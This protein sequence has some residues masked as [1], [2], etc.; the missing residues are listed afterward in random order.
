[1]SQFIPNFING[2]TVES[3]SARLT[4][5]FNPATGEQTKQVKL[6]TAAEVDSAIAAAQA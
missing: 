6:S 3:Q 1:M 2:K 5:V 4:P